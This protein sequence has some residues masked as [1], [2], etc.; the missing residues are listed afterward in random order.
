MS[1]DNNSSY[2]SH[3]WNDAYNP[4]GQLTQV[5][6]GS[7]QTEAYQHD[8][9]G[10][11]IS[12][13]IGNTGAPATT[14]TYSRGLL[15]SST[16]SGQAS[17]YNYDP[18]GRL[19]TVTGPGGTTEQSS[20]YDGFDNLIANTPGSGS[21]ATTT[22][23]NYDP[24][25]RVTSQTTGTNTT[26]YS[27]LG[28][29]SQVSSET[30]P[31]N[32]TKTYGYTPDGTR[33]FQ[34]T[35]G[36]P[37]PSL[38]GTAY[39]SYNN[40][41]DVEALTGPSGTP[42]ATYGYTA[43]GSPVTSMFTGADATNATPG[44]DV[45]PYNSNRFNAMPWDPGSGQ[46]N[47]GARNYQPGTGSFT[48]ADMYAGASADMALTSDPFSGGA[49]AFGDANPISNI[50][51]DGHSWCSWLPAGCGVI[52]N[53]YHAVVNTGSSLLKGSIDLG[54]AIIGGTLR[55]GID[56]LTWIVAHHSQIAS[57]ASAVG[58]AAA[59]VGGLALAAAGSTLDIG[60]GGLCLTGVGCIAGAPAIAAGTAVIAT[61][62][63][64]SAWGAAGLGHDLGTL[65]QSSGGS[66]GDPGEPPAQNLVKANAKYVEEVTGEN[67]EDIK[68]EIV[69]KG[70]SRYDLYYDKNTGDLYVL[71]KGGG[72][73]PQP[74]GLR[75]PR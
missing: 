72:G 53:A 64:V 67:P 47:M 42:T 63:G 41:S 49:Y 74:T 10:D 69:G 5:S 58:H 22:S 73:E 66:S 37:T 32:I 60:G 46:Y 21:S 3:T 20:T 34:T 17:T 8:P 23:Y 11:I 70:G 26:S 75:L 14:Y 65:A 45:V 18:L 43:Y 68:A 40:H 13:T 62:I 31:G 57:I 6:D 25:N 19:D 51:L 48:T 2:L 24:L 39:Y 71:R 54:R 28:L 61:G 7:T 36:D 50:E 27:Y 59:V 30:D 15:Q 44:P 1:A 12:Q 38:N 35:A 56:S 9:Q 4:V 29:T 52:T 55:F 16:T 33:L